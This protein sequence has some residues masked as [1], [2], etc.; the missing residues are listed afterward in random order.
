MAQI[1]RMK[2]LLTGAFGNVG[3]HVLRELLTQG[4]AVRAFDV[5]TK[6]TKSRARDYQDEVEVVWGDIARDDLA[7]ILS[8]QEAVIHLAWMLP[9]E[10]ERRP[11]MSQTINVEGSRRLIQAMERLD[12]APKLIFASSYS[13]HGD[14]ID[15]DELLTPETPVQPL[16]HYTRQKVQ[17]EELVQDSALTWCI[18]RLG[19]V[20]SAKMALG[21]KL[22]PLIF[23]LPCASKQEFIHSDDAAT[24]IANCLGSDQIWGKTLM[25]GGGPTCQL[26]Y[27][28]LINRQLR[29][30]GIGDLPDDAFSRTA[31]Q[32]GGWMD[33]GESQELLNYQRWTFEEH[34]A[35]LQARAGVRKTLTRALAPAI[36]WQLVRQSP[37]LDQG[38]E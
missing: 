38:E 31:R 5:Q 12:P 14:T 10:S 21:G 2:V 28:D 29:V 17:V 32:G 18:L 26:R 6:T 3:W 7:P 35:D 22:D 13:I 23:D 1:A 34:L 15:L 20:L 24:A 33:T 37:Y 8:D 9:P 30:L 4:H 36:R 27:I 11:L 16:N 25:I 19:A